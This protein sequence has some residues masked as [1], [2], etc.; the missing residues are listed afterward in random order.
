[1]LLLIA[2]AVLFAAPAAAVDYGHDVSWPQCQGGLPMPPATT[3]FVVVGLTHGLAFTENPCLGEQMRWVRDHRVRAQAYLVATFPTPAQ[4]DTYG[5]GG[6]W[7]SSTR[8][9]RLRNVGYAEGRAA[10]GSLNGVRWHPE[11]VWVDV[12]PRPR[13]PWPT[14]TA[15]QR[16]ENRFVIA[17]ILVALTDAGLRSGVYSYPNGWRDITGSWSLPSVPVWSAAGRLDFASEASDLCVQRG[18][19]GGT[20]QLA[21]WTDGTY[22]HDMTCSDVYQAHVATIGW[23][24]SVTDGA[25]GGTTGRSLSLEA[26]RLSVAGSRWSGDL[27]WRGHVQ[28]IGWQPWATSASPIGTTGRGLRL[29]AFELRLTGTL[30]AHYRVRYRAHVQGV[31]WQPWRIDGAVAGTVGRGLRMEAV[32]IELVPNVAPASTATDAAH[33]QPLA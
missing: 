13:Q 11:R 18:F 22:D 15:T 16:Q 24:P 23:L 14:S 3:A 30:A 4:Y 6:P 31:G 32:R 20:V 12:E 33:L 21:Q 2:V 29:E 5:T 7:P 17:G 26:L 19:S 1:M 28:R 9:D 25:T 8:A 10:L 27:L